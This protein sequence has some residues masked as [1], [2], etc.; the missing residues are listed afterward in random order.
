[1]TSMF[2]DATTF[3]QDLSGWCVQDIADPPN[4]FA[5]GAS[6]FLSSRYP[7]WGMMVASCPST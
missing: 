4:N 1:M 5:T 7:K 2:R 3:N 6:R